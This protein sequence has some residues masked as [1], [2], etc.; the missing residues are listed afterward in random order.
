MDNYQDESL[1]VIH[2]PLYVL[3]YYLYIWYNVNTNSK[4]NF[5]F[6]VLLLV[7][8]F[9]YYYLSLMAGP[10]HLPNGFV[11]G[12]FIMKF[13]L[14]N[15]FLSVGMLVFVLGVFGFVSVSKAEATCN[16]VTTG[17]WTDGTKWTGCA[18]SNGIP[19]AADAAII[20]AN[21]VITVNATSPTIASITIANPAAT[22]ANGII[23]PNGQT[24]AVTGAVTY[25]ANSGALAQTITMN[26][27]G[28]LTTGTDF[29]MPAPTGAGNALVACNGTGTQLSITGNLA[30]TGNSISTGKSSL[31]LNACTMVV[32][33]TTTLTGGSNAT[34]VAEITATT[35]VMNFNSGALTF[36]GTAGNAIISTS[37]AA[38]INKIGSITGGSAASWSL[39]AGTTLKF[40]GT[41]SIETAYTS[42]KKVWIVSGT[43]TFNAT[44]TVTGLQVDSGATLASVANLITNTG[45]GT[46]PAGFTINGTWSGTGGATLSGIG[47]TID[48]TGTITNNGVLTLT[49]AKTIA[50][51]AVLSLPGTVALST[52]TTVTNNG[53][54]TT[55]GAAGITGIDGT[56]IW[57]N[58]A[59]TSVLNFGG[60]TTSLLSTGVLTATVTGN[61]VNYTAATPTCKVTVYDNL[62][63]SGSGTVTCAATSVTGDL[64]LSGTVALAPTGASLTIGDVLT[65][66]TGT[67]FTLPG[68][69]V[70]VTG[71]T[72]VTGTVDTVTAATGLKTFTGAVTINSGGVWNLSGQNPTTSF[73]GGITMSGTTFNN[74]TG[75]AAFSETQ[76]LAGAVLMTF[77]GTVT[78][79]VTKTLTNNNTVGV[80]V[81]STGSIV[82]TGN[83]TQGTNGVLTLAADAPFSGA[84][85]FTGSGTGNTV[86][87]TG[88]SVPIKIGTYNNLTINGSV[89]A[90]VGSATVVNGTMTVTSAVTNN[91]TLTVTTALAGAST[92]V[93]SATGTLNIGFAGAVG[94]TTLTATASGNTVNYTAASPTCKVITYDNL[95]FSGSG[96]VTCAAT[97][98]TGDLTLS[99]T[100][101]LT[102]SGASL[103]IGDVLTVG[104]GT[105]FT[106]PGIAVTVT[107]ATSVT[108]TLN[109]V[110]AA[111]GTKTFTGAVT[112]NALGTWNLSTTN[113]ATSF[114][115]GITMSGTT[116]N[117]GT[118]SASFTANQA[119]AGAEAMTF[120][121]YLIPSGG[122]TLTNNNTGT[123][124]VSSTGSITLLGNFTQGVNSILALAAAAPF[125][126]SGG[127]FDASTNANT[128]NYTGAAQTVK[129]VNY[130]TLGLSG[131]GAKTVTGVTT[132]AT[133]FNM[134]GSA[135][136]TPVITTV[137]GN[138]SITGTAV[139]TTGAIN[140]VTGTLTVGTGATLTMGAFALTIGG[141]SDITGTIN[142]TSATGTKTFTGTA[143][144][145]TG[146]VWDF[147]TGGPAVSLAAGLTVD[148]TGTFSSGAGVYTFANGAAQTLGGTRAITITTITNSDTTGNGLTLQDDGVTITTLTQGASSVLTFA[149][150]IPTITTLDADTNTNTVQYTGTSQAVK[151]DTYS[152]LTVNGGGTATVGGTTVVNGT[153]TATSAVTNNSTLTVTTALAGLLLTNG[154]SATLNLGGT[155]TVT[156]LT[157]TAASNTVNYTASGAQTVKDPAT[158]VDYVNL[159]LSGSGAKS[160]A[161]NTDVSG[162]I[163]MGGT[164]KITLLTDSL[165]SADKL[166]FG[167]SLQRSG[168][169]G[170]AAATA[171]NETDTYFTAGVTY[172]ITVASGS[173]SSSGGSG[174]GGGSTINCGSLYTLVNGACVAKVVTPVV[175]PAVVAP[176]CSGG[177]LFN[178]STGAACVNNAVIPQGCSGGNLFNTQTGAA[179]PVSATPATPATPAVPGVSSAT[180]ATPATP[181][182]YNFGTTTLKNGSKGEGVKEL[183]RFLN[184]KLNLGLVIDGKLGPKTIAVIK[185]WQKNNGLVADGLVGAKTKAMMNAQ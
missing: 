26:G 27:T 1:I 31:G 10:Y 88:A 100:V 129:A 133:N 110:T 13:N 22:G 135:T 59:S 80:T 117:N 166:Y 114:G 162:N 63:F 6:C 35:G 113:P 121:G 73:A 127:T 68:I 86:T 140:V 75:A 136:A 128:V 24:L 172:H 54:I 8:S 177:N 49:G 169:W 155:S 167:T 96:T 161:S 115:A 51:T 18:G 124:T 61:T 105:T 99:G 163:T 184:V 174:G 19:A 180:P 159:G 142:T 84:G 179:C 102:P 183:Q 25:T 120:G 44:Q 83:F 106:M 56:S 176:G 104:S 71:A 5:C 131:S 139:M 66:G 62:K 134:S 148:G 77:G 122:T 46:G 7:S 118:G 23:I 12:K 173:S 82:L 157:A 17:D 95:G 154:A 89:T 72:S 21:V 29:T 175:I 182:S 91:S 101:S 93:N 165:S 74:G 38:T 145:N 185:T 181:A 76:A 141:I 14:K 108:G 67:T 48:G 33:G 42:L 151:A 178:T 150:A 40:T 32:A 87:Y 37:D 107:G 98:V 130:K 149:G 153:L 143:T 20:N 50:S 168:T 36:G 109:T 123:V 144:V 152:S 160:I 70:T 111:T 116:F 55:T 90:T 39:N 43:T 126:E 34:G 97:S 60:A 81:A 132:I 11:S 138:V 85:T 28:T 16:A 65:V 57:D 58:A 125:S 158:A 15:V 170:A 164:A 45:T 53:A 47:A 79:A 30:M 171:T 69:A 94:I 156:T 78:P 4:L 119:L 3:L 147:S 103:A 2:T 64:T 146:G 52:A 137:G 9:I 112:I 41:S 92:L